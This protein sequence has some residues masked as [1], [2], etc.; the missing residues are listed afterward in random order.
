MRRSPRGQVALATLGTLAAL[1]AG[2]AT[3]LRVMPPSAERWAKAASFIPYGLVFWLP[4]LLLLGIAA[5]RA[6]RHHSSGRL[7][8][9]VLSLVSAAGL[10]ATV[11]WQAPAFIADRRPVVTASLTV[12]SLNVAR[13]A[14]PDAVARAVDGADV[15]VFVEAAREWVLSLPPSLHRALPYQA[16]G[17]RDLDGG[18]V[19]LSRYPLGTTQVLPDRSFH[20]RSVVVETPQVGPLRVVGV[21]PCNPYCPA[22]LWV[23]EA[24]DLRDWLAARDRSVATVVAGD[25]NAVD[26]HLTMRA[27]YDDGWRSAANL[28]GVGF[29]RTW[30]ANR[31]IPPMIGIDHVLVD[32]RLTATAFSTFEVPGTDHLGVRAVIAGTGG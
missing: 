15:V 28:A 27:L 7:T 8:L 20:Q 4:A 29:V 18:T 10:V 23:K 5:L 1:P 25:F 9:S 24:A 12:I 21:H 2:F 31:R 3:A 14:D 32:G 26:D 30:P 17:D 16:P 22:G 19:I 6:W 13:T 11:A